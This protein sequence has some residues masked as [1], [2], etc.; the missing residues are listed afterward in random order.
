MGD[1][2]QRRLFAHLC[3][4]LCAEDFFC[5][6]ALADIPKDAQQTGSTLIMDHRSVDFDMKRR[7]IPTQMDNE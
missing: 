3:F 4:D 5:L 7:A 1:G 2:E 6:D